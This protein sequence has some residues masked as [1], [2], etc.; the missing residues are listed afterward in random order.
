MKSFK[1][2]KEEQVGLER[3]IRDVQEL[4]ETGSSSGKSSVWARA[5]T[6]RLERLL[7][8]NKKKMVSVKVRIN[9][10]IQ[11]IKK[12]LASSPTEQDP[13]HYKKEWPSLKQVAEKRLKERQQLLQD[14]ISD[15]N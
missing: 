10:E 3:E 7:K 14:N 6:V 12:N 11:D 4:L 13:S 8:E 1:E 15:D 5:E 9:I 2:L